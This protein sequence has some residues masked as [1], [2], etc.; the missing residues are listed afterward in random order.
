VEKAERVLNLWIDMEDFA[1][2]ESEKTTFFCFPGRYQ[3]VFV[4]AGPTRKYSLR[5]V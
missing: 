2:K 5:F 1:W 4:Q 3:N